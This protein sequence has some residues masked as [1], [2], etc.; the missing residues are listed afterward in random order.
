[1]KSLLRELA[2]NPR[3]AQ[4]EWGTDPMGQALA[5]LLLAARWSSSTPADQQKVAAIA[6]R[7]YQELERQLRRWATGDDPFFRRSGDSWQLAAAP[8]DAWAILSRF[9]TAGDLV[10]WRA[11][12]LQV[13][14]EEDPTLQLDPADRPFAAVRDINPEWSEALKYG[15]AFG[16][17]LLGIAGAEP[18]RETWADHAA[19]LVRDLLAK[20]NDDASC[21][22][23]QSLVPVLPLLA[24]GAPEQFL[25]G[26]EK[27]LSG[28]DAVLRKMFTDKADLPT[29]AVSSPHTGLLWA[30]ETVSWSAQYLSRA[31]LELVRLVELDPGGRLSNRPLQ[32]LRTMLLPWRPQT[33]APVERRLT[34]IDMLV[35]RHPAAGWSLV[36]QLLPQLDDISSGT[37]APTLRDWKAQMTV[38]VTEH[39]TVVGHLTDLSLSLIQEKPARWVEFVPRFPDLPPEQ[40]EKAIQALEGISPEALEPTTRSSLWGAVSALVRKHRDF[41]DTHWA[42]PEPPLER[43][44]AMAARL[45]PEDPTERFAYLFGWRPS[46]PGVDRKDHRAYDAAL[47]ELREVWVREILGAGGMDALR[48]LAEKSEVPRFVGFSAAIVAG[49]SLLASLLLDLAGDGPRLELAMSYIGR[50]SRTEG[51]DW[52]AR[53]ST[54]LGA[55][56]PQAAVMFFLSLPNKPATWALVDAQGEPVQEGYWRR[57]SNTGLE[58]SDVTEFAQ[59][60]LAC[61]RPWSAIDLLGMYCLGN[62][63]PKPPA[64][65]IEAALQAGLKPDVSDL[66]QPGS[67]GYDLGA[68]LDRLEDLGTS[69]EALAELELGY[70]AVLKHVRAPKAVYQLLAANPKFFV[71]A[72]C[73]AFRARGEAPAE[74]EPDQTAVWRAR[75]ASDL[76]R[77]WRV[78][79]GT[80]EDGT[81]DGIMLRNWVEVARQLLTAENRVEIGE[82]RIGELLSSSPTGEDGAWPSEPVREIIETWAS[83]NLERGINMGKVNSRDVTTRGPYDGGGLERAEVAQFTA[84]ASQIE[85]RWPRTGRVLRHLAD[86]YERDA[87]MMDAM[88]DERAMEG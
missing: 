74:G 6:G 46:L 82:I 50:L 41:S 10:R 12:A 3:G 4:P 61:G 71:E 72:V 69:A 34:I 2:I 84:W 37:A 26:V 80:A 79:P 49:E 38:S 18:E 76:I 14:S 7:E 43:L 78:L 60:L 17:A 83:E 52:G 25:D 39:L 23:W 32:S 8:L 42:L 59:R 21:R 13:L 54:K 57:V 73:A 28:D 68:L 58:A 1:M 24:E 33:A 66:V 30:L 67:L 27:G 45:S 65:V 36:Q 87:R 55:L 47:D 40:L 77:N 29:W 56:P 20:A 15:L 31:T 86:S 48:S 53:A 16:A 75:V 63:E 9:I 19:Y 85:D 81:L 70:F 11:N 64:E 22:L 62:D 44:D 5:P 35:S 51:P 88:A